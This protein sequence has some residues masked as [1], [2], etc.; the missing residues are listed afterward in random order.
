MRRFW[1]AL[2]ALWLI[3]SGV[4]F[5]A[6]K[7]GESFILVYQLIEQG[8]KLDGT[9]PVAALE[10]YLQAQAALKALQKE[11]PNWN[12]DVV[13]SRLQYLQRKIPPLM[14]HLKIPQ[15]PE[16]APAPA[17]AS[18]AMVAELNGRIDRLRAEN[19]Q[20]VAVMERQENEWREK[21]KEALAARPRALEPGELA[22][23]EEQNQALRGKIVYLES[24]FKRGTEGTEGV[25]ASL[26]EAQREAESL[27]KQ[28]AD[29]S[30]EGPMRKLRDENI[31]LR[32]RIVE[33]N[34]SLIS[35]GGAPALQ[36]QLEAVQRM[37]DEERRQAQR[38]KAENDKLRELVQKP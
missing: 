31:L 29:L 26:V 5:A 14:S 1:G 36:A 37:L 16:G 4:L 6:A 20:L 13:E 27:R 38:L 12:N 30:E 25:R 19:E 3:G 17:E 28:L 33:M 22:R 35:G 2:A 8:D 15:P 34:R 9:Q 32:K 10:K 21:L 18:P 11:F 7:P 24:Q 23:V